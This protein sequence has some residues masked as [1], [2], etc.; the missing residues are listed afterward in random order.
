MY[1]YLTSTEHMSHFDSPALQ[2]LGVFSES[3][4]AQMNDAVGQCDLNADS[5][6]LGGTAS[7]M[8]VESQNI[9]WMLRQT[10]SLLFTTV[11]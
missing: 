2:K 8:N 9:T 1:I 11:F 6:F 4:V 10:L 7:R 3:D 5:C